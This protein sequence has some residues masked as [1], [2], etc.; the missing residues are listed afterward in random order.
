MKEKITYLL[1]E[2]DTERSI[3]GILDELNPEEA[4]EL[5]KDIENIEAEE[6]N[7]KDIQDIKERTAK[8]LYLDNFYPVLQSGKNSLGNV[9]YSESDLLGDNEDAS[10]RMGSSNLIIEDL[11]SRT[12]KSSIDSVDLN[13][14]RESSSPSDDASNPGNV[15]SKKERSNPRKL[16]IIAAAVLLFSLFAW[17]YSSNIALAFHNLISLI[18]GVGI[19]ENNPEILYQL[20]SPVNAENDKGSLNIMS[21]VASDSELTVS[22]SFE[23]ANY[24]DEQLLKDKDLEWKKLKETDRLE[25]PNIYILVDQKKYPMVSG[26]SGGGLIENFSYNFN[27]APELLDPLKTYTLVLEDYDIRAD[28]QLITLEQHQSLD[29]IGITGTHNNISLTA[30]AKLTDHKLR[31]NV[32]PVNYSKYNLISFDHDYDFSYFGKKLTLKTEHGDKNYTLPGS[33]GSGMNAAY[34][35]DVSDGS[36]DYKLYIPYVV[37]ESKEE[38]K[39]TLPIPKVDE[40]VT[41]D[42]EI[43]FENGSVIIKSVEKLMQEGGNKYGDLKI[44]LEYK[45]ADENQQLVSALLTRKSSEGWSIEYDEQGR[46][47]SI[48]YMLENHDKKKLKMYVVKPR[49]VFMNEYQLNLNKYLDDFK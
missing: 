10:L 30:T 1:N 17:K 27:L 7:W 38:E 2:N 40:E 39:V 23:R 8:K 34:T 13:L 3:V 24:T 29:E 4:T 46:V 22:F 32:Y 45:S 14:N 21:A 6:L 12:E 11:R 9:D 36:R 42:K 41:L 37:V 43:A 5:L 28:F 16:Y 19:I 44:N 49:Y 33:Y 25:K 48:Y 35:F 20:K 18:P 26:G 15:S 31:V 47:K